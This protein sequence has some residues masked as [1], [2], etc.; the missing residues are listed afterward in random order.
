MWKVLLVDD[1][2]ISH[3]L[4]QKI[5]Q[6]MKFSEDV[7]STYSV[8]EAIALISNGE[9]KPNVIF[10]DIRM[11]QKNGIIFLEEFNALSNEITHGIKIVMLTSSLDQEERKMAENYDTVIDFFNK[12]LDVNK[13][14]RL[15]TSLS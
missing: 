8:D 7:K 15:E 2:E 10:L 13:L 4:N 5:L 1:E 12:P 11:P 14:Q 6:L 9:W 3:F